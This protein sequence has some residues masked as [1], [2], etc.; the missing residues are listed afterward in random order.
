MYLHR[1]NRLEI[2]TRGALTTLLFDRTLEVRGS[3]EEDG[4]VVT[5]MSTDIS[6]V[7]NS[8]EMV[9]EAW[10]QASEVL[11]GMLLL[12]REVGWLWPVPLVFIFCRDEPP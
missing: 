10:G 1:L 9:H 2:M 4:R 7:Q 3:D 5:L 6:N 8:G 11:G 12:A